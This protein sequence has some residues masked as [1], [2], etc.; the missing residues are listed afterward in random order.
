MQ[1]P[2]DMLLQRMW[3]KP[4]RTLHFHNQ[5]AS[6]DALNFCFGI[7]PPI[8]EQTGELA[9]FVQEVVQTADAEDDELIPQS[10]MSQHRNAS[11]LV[12]L[13][14]ACLNLLSTVMSTPSF[15][16]NNSNLRATIIAIF[17]KYL[18]WKNQDVINAASKGLRR[19]VSQNTKLPKELL[20]AGL[21][22]ILMNMADHKRLTVEG[23]EGLATLLELLNSYFKVEIGK[24]LLDH[25]KSFL[26]PLS[27]LHE[28]AKRSL[29]ELH[30]MKILK[31]I[32]N[33]FHLLPTGAN[34][35]LVDLI[36]I[37]IDLEV[38]LRRTHYSPFRTP[39]LKFLNRYPATVGIFSVSSWVKGI[40][41]GCIH[42]SSPIQQLVAMRET[43][44]K[45]RA[46]L[47]QTDILPRDRESQVSKSLLLSTDC[48]SSAH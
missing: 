20:Q 1:E 32:V 12:E 21:K 36:N 13:R 26:D 45:D 5:I 14:I 10:R 19:L 48:T 22:P 23:L 25:L 15:V 17:F 30:S 9:R 2:K 34:I 18:Y 44:Q 42:K 28:M 43:V 3:S 11:A 39:L 38:T 27:E 29:D 37:V 35:F 4:L 7:Q 24:K 41:E 46:L 31:S 6:I 47:V 8:V 16:Q 40:S 33:V